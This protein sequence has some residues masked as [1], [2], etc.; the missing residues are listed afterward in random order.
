MKTVLTAAVAALIAWPCAAADIQV[1]G[2][3][4]RASPKMAQAGAGFLTIVNS[5]AQDDRLVAAAADISKKVELHTHIKEGDLMMM[6]QV[7]AIAVPAGGR[8]ELKPGGDHVMFMG[9]HAPLKEGTTV[10]VT[11]TFEKAG[12]IAVEMPVQAMGAMAPMPPM[13]HTG[14]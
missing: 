2:A 1:S 6:R 8:A 14:H 3:F 5:G 7:E 4:V 12:K 11:L 10:P 13:A 9:L